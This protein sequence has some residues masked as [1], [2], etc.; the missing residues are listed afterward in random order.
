MDAEVAGCAQR[1]RRAEKKQQ[2]TKSR[3]PKMPACGR[4]NRKSNDAL[5]ARALSDACL[6]L[7]VLQILRVVRVIRA[8][9]L[10]ARV[11]EFL[12]LGVLLRTCFLAGLLFLL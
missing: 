4:S 6:F 9:R 8:T 11:F 3:T 2:T 5:L 10:I 1:R 12:Q 7:R